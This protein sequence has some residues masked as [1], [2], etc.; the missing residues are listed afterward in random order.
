V[1]TRKSFD[2]IVLGV[3]AMGAAACWHLAKR[4]VRV[5]GLEQNGVPNGLG[6]SHG[7]S[8]AIRLAYFEHPDYV[9]LLKRAWELW[10]DLENASGQTLLYK[11]GCL[12]LGPADSELIRGSRHSA[13]THGLPHETLSR[14]AIADSFEPFHVPDDFIGLFETLGGTLR[15][16]LSIASMALESLKHGA[17]IHGQTTVTGWQSQ[18]NGVT[19]QT[20]QGNTYHATHLIISGGAWSSRLIT[21]LGV[22]LMVTRQVLGW[23]WPRLPERFTLE[24][25]FPTWAIEHG[26]EFHYGFPMLPDNPG[27]KI[28]RHAPLGQVTTPETVRRDPTPEDEETFR[29]A[30]R[31]FFPGADGPTLAVRTCLYTNS[32]DGHFILDRHPE[33]NSVTVACGF[34]GHGFKFAPVIGEALADLASTGATSLP[35][36]F[37]GLKRFRDLRNTAD[38]ASVPEQT[39]TLPR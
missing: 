15:P 36:D 18:T 9:P 14:Q 19:V 7:Y 33:H 3:G 31:R 20:A 1:E 24:A 2:V 6:S 38:T 32:P 5:L 17:V 37:L 8:R 22:P 25:G 35:I 26:S 13:Q 28:A 23:V 21:S 29:P 27:F 16:E 10:Q 34:S 12:Y 39:Q 4:G 11:T 30:L